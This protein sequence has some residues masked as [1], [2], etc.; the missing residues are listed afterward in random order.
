ML[1]REAFSLIELVFVIAI[2]GILAAIAIPKFAVT[3]NDAEIAKARSTI[4][5]VRAG[6][7]SE[8]QKRLLTGNTN[9]A[10]SL[11][12]AS[13]MFG[14]VLT[15]PVSDTHWTSNANAYTFTIGGVA[16]T[17]TYNSATGTFDCTSTA[18]N[19]C[20]RLTK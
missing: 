2:L 7:I 4:A 11:D 18:G 17:L 5:A 1:K 14:A 12:N 19:Y 16:T 20:D 13:G 6:I 9:Y 10:A 3:R 15:Y 8:R